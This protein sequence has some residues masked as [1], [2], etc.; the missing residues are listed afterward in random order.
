[1]VTVP[2]LYLDNFPTVNLEAMNA[3]KPVVGTCFGG[4]AEI[5]VSGETGLIVNPRNT[6]GYA[7]ALV[8]LLNDSALAKEMGEKGKKRVETVF[9]LE[10]QAEAY[11]SFLNNK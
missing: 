1:V 9:S 8:R 10:K 4:T 2:S 5:V 7:Q 6:L 11:L 3:G